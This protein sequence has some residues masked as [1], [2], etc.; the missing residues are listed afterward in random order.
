MCCGVL[1]ASA[2]GDGTHF[3]CVACYVVADMAHNIANKT[4]ETPPWPKADHI[5]VDI[6]SD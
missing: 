3:S 6:V 1:G 5:V 4:T 2:W